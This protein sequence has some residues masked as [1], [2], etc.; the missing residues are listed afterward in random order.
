[1]SEVRAARVC[2]EHEVMREAGGNETSG[3][4]GS[5]FGGFHGGVPVEDTIVISMMDGVRGSHQ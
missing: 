5:V 4:L 1:M 3:K 2:Q